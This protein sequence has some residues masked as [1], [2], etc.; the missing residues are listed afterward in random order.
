MGKVTFTQGKGSQMH[1]RRDY[2]RR[3]QPVPENIDSSRTVQNVTVVDVPLRDAYKQIFGEALTEYNAKQTRKDRIISDYVEH[4]QHS[5]NGEKLFYEDVVQW[6]AME[7]FAANPKL[8]ESAKKA[9]TIYAQDFRLRNPNLRVIGAYIHM[10]EA[11]PHLH[12]D[13]IPVATGY[14][15]GLRVRNSL[16]RAL[17]QMGCVPE[18]GKAVDK[19]Y[20]ATQIWRERERVYLSQLFEGFGLTVE[21]AE[22]SRGHSFTPEEYKRLKDRVLEPARAEAA[23][24]LSDAL[25]RAKL[26]TAVILNEAHENAAQAL[27]DAQKAADALSI[28]IVNAAYDEAFQTVSEAQETAEAVKAEVQPLKAEYEAKQA[29]VKAAVEASKPAVLYPESVTVTKKGIIKRQ[30]YVTAPKK[31]W[32]DRTLATYARDSMDEERQQLDEAWEQYR[33]SASGKAYAD[34]KGDVAKLRS[35]NAALSQKL[36]S[37]EQELSK[38]KTELQRLKD[39]VERFFEKLPEQVKATAQRVWQSLSAP[40]RHIGR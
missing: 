35:Q 6:G 3:G 34:L 12:L 13:Y 10:D 16:D 5:K 37:T 23:Q 7:D 39:K 18:Q 20:N 9:L 21:A 30:E 17:Q 8:R 28:D 24:T 2:E 4:V 19:G 1:N 25:R 38:T 31:L 40:L 32:E 26:E 29:L 14:T 15:R 36:S 11:S 27:S 22:R 33:N